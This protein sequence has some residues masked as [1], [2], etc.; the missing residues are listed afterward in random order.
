MPKI[1]N[2]SNS[3][4]IQNLD[5]NFRAGETKSSLEGLVFSHGEIR[6]VDIPKPCIDV[7]PTT[8]PSV[9]W[10][11]KTADITLFQHKTN[12][13]NLVAREYKGSIGIFCPFTEQELINNPANR[14]LFDTHIVFTVEVRAPKDQTTK[15][16][17]CA[18]HVSKGF[19]GIIYGAASTD[20]V[21]KLNWGRPNQ[22]CKGKGWEDSSKDDPVPFQKFGKEFINLSNNIF[23]KAT[24]CDLIVL[25]DFFIRC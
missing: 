23:M 15:E 8:S 6:K 22:D 4:R 12:V 14:S 24:R 3:N 5:D 10:Y 11:Q 9:T 25:E 21:M 17:L 18:V 2:D 19:E 20:E 1:S 16:Q 13:G 7:T